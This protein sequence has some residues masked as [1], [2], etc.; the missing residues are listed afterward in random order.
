M[1]ALY[2]ARTFNGI[3]TPG[4]LIVGG[5]GVD[6]FFIIS[7]YMMATIVKRPSF[8]FD[9]FWR[10]YPMWW[11]AVIPWLFLAPMDGKT[12]AVSL[13]LWP[14]YGGWVS[15]ALLVGW[16][17]CFDIVFYLAIAVSMRTGAMPLIGIYFVLVA[18]T[19]FIKDPILQFL[20]NPMFIDCLLGAALTKLPAD[21]RLAVPVLLAAVILLAISPPWVASRDFAVHAPASAWRVVYWGIPATLLVYGCLCAEHKLAHRMWT[22]LVFLGT[23]S[24][25]IYLFHMMVYRELDLPW[26]VELGAAIL[27]GIVMWWALERPLGA[28][29]PRWK[30]RVLVPAE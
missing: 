4:R 23:A 18:A 21:K 29:K 1:V 27:V 28:M 10:I 9:R 7:G 12:L 6:V 5:A 15:P 13:T 26:V 17:I 2:H 11:I 19:L 25:S 3:A 16:T 30:R 14:I 20:G 22:P 8:L 24:Y